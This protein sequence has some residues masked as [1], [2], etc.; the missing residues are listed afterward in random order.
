MYVVVMSICLYGMFLL[1]PYESANYIEISN[2]KVSSQE[3]SL[4]AAIY[5][6]VIFKHK[7]VTKIILKVS[8][9][10]FH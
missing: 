8:K 7:N 2:V 5:H 1:P 9:H 6:F 10:Y 3:F 4:N